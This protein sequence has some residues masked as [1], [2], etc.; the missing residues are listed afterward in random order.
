[1]ITTEELLFEAILCSGST[2][3]SSR[4]K[5]GEVSVPFRPVQTE[6]K[7]PFHAQKME[8]GRDGGRR[9]ASDGNCSQLF[10]S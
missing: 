9:R 6:V 7:R 8:T 4:E 1:M 10:Q 3:Y 2:T 5:N